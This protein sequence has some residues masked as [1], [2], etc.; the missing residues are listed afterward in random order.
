M[1]DEIE[2]LSFYPLPPYKQKILE[3]DYEELKKWLDAV[4]NINEELISK[5]ELE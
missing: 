4:G 2:K 1:I 3:K 5:K